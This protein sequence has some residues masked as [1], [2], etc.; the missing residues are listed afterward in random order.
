MKWRLIVVGSVVGLVAFV[1]IVAVLVAAPRANEGDR[2]AVDPCPKLTLDYE[3]FLAH[4]T[5]RRENP[6]LPP[7][8]AQ[9]LLRVV[10]PEDLADGL[11][12]P[13][14]EPAE[15]VV[16]GVHDAQDGEISDD[17]LDRYNTSFN[18]LKEGARCPTE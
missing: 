5:G 14:R 16:E 1:A 3:N 4:S 2:T 11:E 10:I 7:A 17:D 13:L 9:R 15:A 8:T 6:D 18:D 12:E